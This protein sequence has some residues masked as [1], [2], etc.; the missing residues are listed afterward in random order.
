VTST[1]HA[2]AGPGTGPSQP[3]SSALTRGGAEPVARLSG[4]TKRFRRADGSVVTAIDDVTLAVPAGQIVVLVGPSGCGK[5][6]LLRAIAGLEAPD[7]GQIEIHGEPCFDGDR[8]LDVPPERRNVS[9]VFQNYALWPH[10]TAKQN[11]AYPLRADRR[12]RLGRAEA[13]RKAL[14]MLAVVGIG[15]LGDQHPHQMSGGQRQRVALAR[16]LVAGSDLVL[17][18]EPLSN[19]DA[20]VRT[21]LRREL[22]TMQRSLGFSAVFVTHDQAEAME[23]ADVLAVMD[24]GRLAQ[25]GPPQQVYERPVSR[26]VAHVIGAANELAGTVR[27]VDGA[28]VEVDTAAGVLHGRSARAAGSGQNGSQQLQVG[29]Q[30]VAFWRPEATALAVEE[31]ADGNRWPGE[32]TAVHHLGPHTEYLV[33]AA[34]R[35]FSV[36]Q[37]GIGHGIEPGPAWLGVAADDVTVMP[38]GTDG[39]LPEQD[40]PS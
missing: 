14:D 34:D 25:I 27:A 16:A 37:P 12:T 28:V 7:A 19:V 35:S 20:K 39:D 29:D 6:T 3:P 8:G 22:V 40:G 1:E 18:D 38:G 2:T 5:T 11:V 36:W 21:Q 30:V 24:H 32:V 26:Y 23:L 33:R 4:L 17:F 9:M 31:P 13:N 10:L 15:D